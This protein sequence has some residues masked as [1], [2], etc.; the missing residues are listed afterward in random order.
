MFIRKA[1]HADIKAL[2]AIFNTA[3]AT[4]M[5]WLPKLHSYAGD[6]K[7]FENR[8]LTQYHVDLVEVDGQT[9]GFISYAGDW[10]EQLYIDPAH[11]RRGLG[12]ALMARAKASADYLQLWV[13]LQNTEAQ[14]F[15]AK[16]GFVEAE[17][18]DG[19]N[20]EE[21]CPDIRMVWSREI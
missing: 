18:T 2:V 12:T 5:P 10:L 20:N 16:H 3:R 8:V 4:A 13:F 11:Q 17:R 7:F 15:Y 1:E 19:S 6:L 21:R 9:A 14:A